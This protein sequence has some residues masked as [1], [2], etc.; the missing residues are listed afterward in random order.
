MQEDSEAETS[1]QFLKEALKGDEDLLAEAVDCFGGQDALKDFVADVQARHKSFFSHK[2]PADALK[3]QLHGEGAP[4]I[5]VI[6]FS[7]A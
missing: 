3:R 1:E 6:G 5:L 4:F 2:S 7:L